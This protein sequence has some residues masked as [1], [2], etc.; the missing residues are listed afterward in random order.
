[1]KIVKFLRRIFLSLSAYKYYVH[2]LL[3]IPYLCRSSYLFWI[4][5][6]RRPRRPRIHIWIANMSKINMNE[7]NFKRNTVA[8]SCESSKTSFRLCVISYRVS[9]SST[10]DS[11]SWKTPLKSTI[12]KQAFSPTPTNDYRKDVFPTVLNEFQPRNLT[13]QERKSSMFFSHYLTIRSQN[14]YL[15]NNLVNKGF[16]TKDMNK[17]QPF[18]VKAK[19]SLHVLDIVKP[20]SLSWRSKILADHEG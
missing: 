17:K 8:D 11:A 2:L 13:I 15:K 10:K 16:R 9:V 18:R 6:H 12:P 19:P 20:V 1:M 7:A 3:Q 4:K 14:I 5:Y